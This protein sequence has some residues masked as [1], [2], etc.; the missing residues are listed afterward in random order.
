MKPLP[1]A[2]Q[3]T[4]VEIHTA[5]GVFIK[6]MVIRSYGTIVPQ[7]AHVWDHTSMLAAGSVAVWREGQF[8][9]TYDAPAAIFIKAGVKHLFQSLMPNTIIYCIHNLHGEQAVK[10]LEEH[11]LTGEI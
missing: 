4:G 3:P 11:Q 9:R 5:D 8:D 1:S 6:Q 10:I 2:E 7:H